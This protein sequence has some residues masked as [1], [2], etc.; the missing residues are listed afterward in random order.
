MHEVRKL[1]R[2]GNVRHPLAAQVTGYL[3]CQ[4]L[5]HA[6]ALR[7]TQERRQQLLQQFIEGRSKGL[8]SIAWFGAH[9][10]QARE[11][12]RLLHQGAAPLANPERQVPTE[13]RSVQLLLQRLRRKQLLRNHCCDGAG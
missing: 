13:L 3:L 6:G 10:M 1:F 7:R 12:D 8:C 2:T 5:H 9:A 4:R 11:T